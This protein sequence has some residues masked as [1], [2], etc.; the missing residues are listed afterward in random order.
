M[1]GPFDTRAFGDYLT[2]EL[3]AGRVVVVNDV[4][5][6]PLKAP[7]ESLVH[8]DNAGIA[9]HVTVPLFHASRLVSA[10][11]VHSN[12]P[13]I[14]TNEEITLLKIVVDRTW[15]IVEVAKQHRALENEV[16]Q[17]R[18][19]ARR[20]AQFTALVQNSSD[21]LGIA[22]LDGKVIF[23]N[24]AGRRLIGLPSD[25]DFDI[26]SMDVN[27][28]DLFFPEDLDFV[29]NEFLPRVVQEGHGVTEI[30]FRHAVTGLPVWVDYAKFVVR[31]PETDEITAL[32]SITR[33]ISERRRQEAEQERLQL[34]ER[35]IAQQL[36]SALLPIQPDHLPGLGV[37]GYY[38]AALQ[39][40]GVGG[41]FSDGFSCG[42]G[43]NTCFVVADVSGKGLRAAS[44]VAAIRNMFRFAIHQSNSIV[45]AVSQLNRVFVEQEHLEGFATFFAG[46]FD[47]EQRSFTYVNCGQEP[48]LVWRTSSKSVEYLQATG[49]VL[50]AYTNDN[51]TEVTISLNSGDVVALF[52][53]GLTEAGPER[54]RLL[55]ID[56][57]SRLFANSVASLGRQT[58]T[59][60]ENTASAIAASIV[61]SLVADI[62]QYAGGADALRDDIVLLVL[63]AY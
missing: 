9:A 48:G 44:Q 42:A 41:D 57:V 19:I 47:P 21:F 13:R 63:I 30:R 8:Y 31:D 26:E 11:G 14:W 52:T 28:R 46:V 35:N 3:E 7:V 29:L 4:R 40:A 54:M 45:T 49:S 61:T 10:I 22:R 5:R 59:V 39:E 1:S 18:E 17:R 37:R 6:E 27:V 12:L 50:G 51:F 56:G 2:D 34:R 25:E 38:R 23:L 62:E 24:A 20:Q 32:M 43:N 36:Q 53:D 58:T 15:L 60:S 55:G 33:D 16:T